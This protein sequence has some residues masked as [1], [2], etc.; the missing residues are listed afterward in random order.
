MLAKAGRG[1]GIWA[2]AA[3][4]LLGIG[5]SANFLLTAGDRPPKTVFEGHGTGHRP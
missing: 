3:L 4:A 1:L 2:I 5:Q